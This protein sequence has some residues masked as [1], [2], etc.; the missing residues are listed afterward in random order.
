MKLIYAVGV[1]SLVFASMVA[2]SRAAG[3]PPVVDVNIVGS[4]ASIQL[5]T[6]TPLNT[7]IGNEVESHVTNDTNNPVPTRD[8]ENPARTPFQASAP[9]A[10]DPP[11]AGVFGTP[12]YEVPAGKRAVVEYA[13]VRCSSPAG[14]P[15]TQAVVQ[16][17][18]LLEG[19]GSI[20][21]S[22]EIPIAFQGTDAFSGPLYIGGLGMRLYSDRGPSGGGITAG[23]SRAS[24]S[25]SGSC[26]FAISGHLV[27]L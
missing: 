17:T 19:G 20:S 11:F 23:A 3:G 7:I 2:L 25:G 9:I 1:S 16:V 13:S 6:T 21:R 12:L 27:T 5:D 4:D 8:V 10:L 14:N 26:S 15:M 22:F 18:E 24:G